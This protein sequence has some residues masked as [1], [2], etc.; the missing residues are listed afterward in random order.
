MFF[1]LLALT[2][3]ERRSISEY[4]SLYGKDL[5][6]FAYRLTLSRSKAEDLFQQTWLKVVNNLD[7][8]RDDN[9]KSWLFKICSNQFKDNY[10]KDKRYQ[11]LVKDDYADSQ[12]K[13]FVLSSA[14][15]NEHTEVKVENRDRKLIILGH[16][17]NLPEKQRQVILMFYYRAMKYDEIAA[18]LK[19]PVGTVR[20]RINSAKKTLKTQMEGESYV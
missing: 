15:S 3:E 1:L 2:E 6:N 7:K 18:L 19:C 11:K 13:D 17:N 8:Y 14:Q 10:R 16:I 20:S 4:V 5:Y 9:F 12:T